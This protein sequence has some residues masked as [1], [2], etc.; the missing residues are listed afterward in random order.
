MRAAQSQA[1]GS[2]PAL[3][4]LCQLHWSPLCMFAC[5]RGV[6]RKEVGCNVSDRD[7]IDDEI[8]ALCSALIASGGS[9]DP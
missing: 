4:E 1:P 5:L 6:L 2:Q 8:H 7:E 3:A 9:L